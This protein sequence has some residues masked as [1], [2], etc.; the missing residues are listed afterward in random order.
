MWLL[1]VETETRLVK[2]QLYLEIEKHGAI[3]L[4]A[5][6]CDICGKPH[7]VKFMAS[8][9]IVCHTFLKIQTSLIIVSFSRHK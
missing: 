8:T 2:K 3:W 7:T 4:R 6:H 5:T 9:T 1:L